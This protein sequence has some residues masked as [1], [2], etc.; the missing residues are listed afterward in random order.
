MSRG[1]RPRCFSGPGRWAWAFASKSR[2]NDPEL[3]RAVYRLC[4]ELN[5]FGIFEVEFVSYEGAWA[6]ID[7][8]PRMFNQVGMDIRRGMPLPLFAY[9][10]A[11]G[12]T[13]A[14]RELVAKAQNADDSAEVVFSDRFTL[15]AILFAQTLLARTL[16]LQARPNDV[17]YWR[18]WMKRTAANTVDVAADAGDPVPAI[19]HVLSE[20]YLGLRAIPRFLRAMPPSSPVMTRTLQKAVR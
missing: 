3:S 11:I 4:R 7:F 9:L 1:V 20:I 13:I 6:A 19:V 15:R 14:L 5:Y 10:D 17:A 8:N 2:P 18:A 12:D 16:G